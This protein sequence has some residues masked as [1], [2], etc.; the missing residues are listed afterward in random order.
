MRHT[1]TQAAWQ[2]SSAQN[3]LQCPKHS[4]LR[5]NKCLEAALASSS[6][7]MLTSRYSEE[8][9]VEETALLQGKEVPTE[10]SQGDAQAAISEVCSPVSSFFATGRGHP[11]LL[12]LH[13]GS[14]WAILLCTAGEPPTPA[15][16]H[17]KWR[18]SCGGRTGHSS[19]RN[20]ERRQEGQVG[21]SC[22]SYAETH[23]FHDL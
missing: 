13:P 2:P 19:S 1:P 21:L 15:G 9:A 12:S 5:S 6:D 23:G 3:R 22:M 20:D 17:R 14:E 16:R 4:S 8:P 7:R 11:M 18:P 10:A